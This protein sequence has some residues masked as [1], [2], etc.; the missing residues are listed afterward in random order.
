M[1]QPMN[2]TEYLQ[3]LFHWPLFVLFLFCLVLV[4]FVW[5]C[6]SFLSHSASS[7][8]PSRLCKARA[9]SCDMGSNQI[10]HW[11]T[12][13]TSADKYPSTF[14]RQDRCGSNIL[15]LDWCSSPTNKRLP[16]IQKMDGLDLVSSITE[17][18][19]SCHPYSFH[20]YSFQEVSIIRSFH[21]FL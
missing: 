8:W 12:T 20:P 16:W 18:P 13:S 14:Y 7:S 5:F 4:Y 2:I 19:Y 3:K 6:H 17:S 11:M 9:P 1:H 10:S 15:Q 21:I